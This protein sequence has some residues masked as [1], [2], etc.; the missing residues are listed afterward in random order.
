MPKSGNLD[1]TNL[2]RYNC[3]CGGAVCVWRFNFLPE[4]EFYFPGVFASCFHGSCGQGSSPPYQIQTERPLPP[5]AAF[6]LYCG[7]QLPTLWTRVASSSLSVDSS[8]FLLPWT[9]AASSFCGF[10]HLSPSVDLSRFLLPWTGAASSFRGI[11]QL[12]PS[13]DSSNFLL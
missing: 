1:S 6:L 5:S 2:S 3:S 7:F 13:V 10:E 9:R 12:S 4:I 8:R 11:E